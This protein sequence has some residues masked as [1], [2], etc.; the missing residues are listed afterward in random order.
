[1]RRAPRWRCHSSRTPQ[2]K[3]TIGQDNRTF[4]ARSLG[5][6]VI[7]E[8]GDNISIGLVTLSVQE[9]SVGDMVMMQKAQ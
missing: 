2:S 6:V 5:E 8:V 4:P 9:M 7:V 3:N 1:M